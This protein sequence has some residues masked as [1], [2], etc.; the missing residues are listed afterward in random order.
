MWLLI[1][2]FEE[3]S[4]KTSLPSSVCSRLFNSVSHSLLKPSF[5]YVWFSL[6][7]SPLSVTSSPWMPTDPPSPAPVVPDLHGFP[8]I[9]NFPLILC[10]CFP[11]PSL[12]CAQS[13]FPTFLI[14]VCSLCS[15]PGEGPG[16]IITAWEITAIRACMLTVHT[17]TN[18]AADRQMCF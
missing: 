15:S 4:S 14:F 12:F 8:W 1:L 17:C 3:R 13:C 2:Y 11:F 7:L 5:L 16:I 6:L 18:T 9:L 10:L